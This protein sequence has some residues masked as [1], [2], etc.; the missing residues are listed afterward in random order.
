MLAFW[1]Y[2]VIVIYLIFMLSIGGICRKLNQDSSD[3]FRG[4]GSMLW[5]MTGASSFAAAF[6]AYSFTAAGSKVYETGFLIVVLY[7]LSIIPSL[8]IFF[9]FAKRYRQM[10]VITSCDAIERRFGKGIEQLYVWLEI[11]TTLFWGGTALYIISLF[12]SS[13]LGVNLE[14]CS[15]VLGLTVL[16]MAMS[17]GSWAVVVSDFVQLMLIIVVAITVLVRTLN[18]PELGGISG[19]ID[20]IPPHFTDFDLF[21]RPSVWI[22]FLVLTLIRGLLQAADIND[23]GAKFLTAKDGKNAQKSVL[24]TIVGMI[25]LP[26]VAFVPIMISATLDLDLAAMYP[27]LKNPAEAAY[28]AVA[29]SVLPEG[30]VGLLVCAIFAASMSSMDTALNRNAGI[31]VKNFYINYINRNADESKQLKAGRIT[32][33]VCGILIIA[34]NLLFSQ[35]RDADL[36]SLLLKLNVLLMFPMIIPMALGFLY[37]YASARSA[38]ATTIVCFLT[39]YIAQ[40][41]INYD[42]VFSSLGMSMP[43]NEMESTDM[44][45]VFS[46]AVTI[47]VGVAC[48]F[49]TSIGYEKRASTTYKKQVEDFFLD[50]KTPISKSAEQTAEIDAIQYKIIGQVCILY[51]A[52]ISL[53]FFI[54]N[55]MNDR[56]LFIWSGGCLSLL[57]AFMHFIYKRKSQ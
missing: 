6:S 3:Y 13:A 37:P 29:S 24:I 20:K 4:G 9:V 48:F 12:V 32:T 23:Q 22:L 34:I 38:L 51:G 28:L 26:L 36:F 11:P 33:I 40:N 56:L 30:F 16:I 7:M 43:L 35:F 39:A 52:T 55:L 46:G 45:Y 2:T 14:L 53:G 5:W 49:L 25:F 31:F 18:I 17:G 10:R 50:M 15:V 21:A 41:W 57:G 1:D 8:L 44:Q 47:F 27:N 19:F 54:P 42:F